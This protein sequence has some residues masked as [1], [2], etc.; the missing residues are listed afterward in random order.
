MSTEK[1]GLC[2]CMGTY[3]INT[4][5]LKPP[6]SS[7]PS[8]NPEE[9]NLG[10]GSQAIYYKVTSTRSRP[11]PKGWL[12]NNWGFRRGGGGGV[13]QPR[14]MYRYY[15]RYTNT[16]HTSQ[17]T[18]SYCKGKYHLHTCKVVHPV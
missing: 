14:H 17:N 5:R 6:F 10:S 1:R 12:Y 15:A 3:V 16:L 2:H 18:Y 9:R 4:V 8:G 7:H 11:K 13:I